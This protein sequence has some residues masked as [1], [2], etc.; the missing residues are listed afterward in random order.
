V[1]PDEPQMPAQNPDGKMNWDDYWL[2]AQGKRPKGLYELGAEFYRSQIIS[3]AG[4]RLLRRYLV[5]ESNR[6][7]LHAGCGSGGSDR[8]ITLSR[9][10]FV[11]LDNSSQALV[12]NRAQFP[13]R[14]GTLLC[15]DIRALPLRSE[16]LDG[17]FNFGVME[18][19]EENELEVILSEFRRVLKPGGRMVLFWPPNFGLSVMV[20]GCFLWIVNR[21]R[22]QKLAFY[23]DEVSRIPSFRW[24]RSLMRRTGFEVIRN[25]FG[26][27]DLFTFVTV[28]AE[29]P[30]AEVVPSRELQRVAPAAAAL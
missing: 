6:R 2:R 18:H 17:I 15:G 13:E 9:P 1:T 20:L 28:V 8:R 4:A 22:T 10:T 29:K 16:S 26:P 25:H 5:D 24:A 30:A 14:A 23:P 27:R 12:T 21:F 7:Y 19:F 3:R 11:A